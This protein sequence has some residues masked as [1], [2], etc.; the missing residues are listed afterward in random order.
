MRIFRIGHRRGRVRPK[1]CG[2][3]H[4]SMSL[5]QKP[6]KM[7]I[8]VRQAGGSGPTVWEGATGMEK[9]RGTGRGPLVHQTLGN[10]W[11]SMSGA[12]RYVE[13]SKSAT[14]K[15]FVRIAADNAGYR[16]WGEGWHGFLQLLLQS[17]SKSRGH[18]AIPLNAQLFAKK[19][20]RTMLTIPPPHKAVVRDGI[21]WDAAN[22][23]GTCVAITDPEECMETVEMG[24]AAVLR[25][26]LSS[27][28]GITCPRLRS[29]L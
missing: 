21:R 29:E 22:Q 9:R 16:F 14:C 6:L 4:D 28:G 18:L 19:I 5:A 10:S 13:C 7:V 27:G 3:D 25:C 26:L 23:T 24:G 2:V 12:E 20:Q 15:R 1:G 17:Q 11:G 8:Q